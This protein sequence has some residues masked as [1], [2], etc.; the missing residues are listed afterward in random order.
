M[1]TFT[2]RTKS[3]LHFRLSVTSVRKSP[4]RKILIS[5][6]SFCSI[7]CLQFFKF[8]TLISPSFHTVVVDI[9]NPKK[10]MGRD[11]GKQ[12]HVVHPRQLIPQHRFDTRTQALCTLV[13]PRTRCYNKIISFEIETLVESFRVP[14]GLENAIT[15]SATTKGDLYCRESPNHQR[16]YFVSRGSAFNRVSSNSCVGRYSWVF[17]RLTQSAQGKLDA[18]QCNKRN[19]QQNRAALCLH[20]CFTD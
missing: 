19:S 13:P 12:E 15:S 17:S 18:R 9:D 6:S 10:Q 14:A 16:H 8:H 4:R 11:D 3:T 20:F 2:R 5:K 1:L 7:Q